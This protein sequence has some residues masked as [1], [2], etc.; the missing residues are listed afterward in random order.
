[1]KK[2]LIT[3]GIL[4]G[5]LAMQPTVYAQNNVQVREASVSLGKASQNAVV[6]DYNYS[7]EALDAVV[8][9]RLNAAKLS[10]SKSASS[11]FRIFGGVTWTEISPNKMDYY[12]R[13]SGSKGKSTLEILASTGYDNFVTTQADA[14]T[15]QNI[16]TFMASLE[17]DLIKYSLDELIVAKE[18]EIKE[19]EKTLD[20]KKNTVSKAEK[21][22][23]EAKKE[24]QKQD[25]VLNALKGELEKLKAQR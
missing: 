8:K 10:K 2:V 20:N 4:L 11:K 24:T 1:M 12:Y 5:S 14:A 18:K 3:F 21:S 19:A 23:E 17:A 16:K 6:A 22:L 9:S 15:I 13:V 25:E 7:K